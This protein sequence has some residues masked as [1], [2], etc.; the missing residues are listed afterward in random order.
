MGRSGI[1]QDL[2]IKDAKKITN[3]LGVGPR[4]HPEKG[5]TSR[6]SGSLEG[7]PREGNGHSDV[8]ESLLGFWWGSM[9]SGVENTVKRNQ[10][11]GARCWSQLFQEHL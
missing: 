1:C 4:L 3:C 7:G 8:A 10:G 9:Q 6:W 11:S 2:G 5:R